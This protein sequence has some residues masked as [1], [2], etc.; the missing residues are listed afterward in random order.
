ME[1]K[2]QEGV[3][4]MHLLNFT[5]KNFAV[6]DCREVKQRLPRTLPFY[7]WINGNDPAVWN[8]VSGWKKVNFRK[9]KKFLFGL[10]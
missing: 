8:M 1:G 5:Q 4:I 10:I 7:V 3:S 6:T 2:T 9:A